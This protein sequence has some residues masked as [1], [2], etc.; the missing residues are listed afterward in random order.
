MGYV[1][2]NVTIFQASC[3]KVMGYPTKIEV[4]L[5]EMVLKLQYFRQVA[6]NP[7]SGIPPLYVLILYITKEY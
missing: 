4:N 2:Y 7:C 1:P 3:Q 6:G 5:I